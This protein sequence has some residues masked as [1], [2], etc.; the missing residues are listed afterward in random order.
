MK[1]I[2]KKTFVDK[3]QNVIEVHFFTALKNN[4]K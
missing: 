3:E 1:E 4:E 2:L